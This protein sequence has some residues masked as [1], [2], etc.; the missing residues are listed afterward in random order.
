M[1]VGRFQGGKIIRILWRGGGGKKGKK[2]QKRQK[3]SGGQGDKETRRQ[4]DKDKETSYPLSPLVPL[5]A[6]TS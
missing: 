5:S 6:F 2:E 1:I 4:G 3:G